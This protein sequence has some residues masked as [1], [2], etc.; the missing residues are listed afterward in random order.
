MRP[1]LRRRVR[2]SSNWKL[3][4][5]NH[6]PYAP[7]SRPALFQTQRGRWMAEI[8]LRKVAD[9]LDPPRL[10]RV[11]QLFRDSRQLGSGCHLERVLRG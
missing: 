8:R 2:G 1:L 5:R 7:P 9:F 3:H 6:F 4:D 10:R 11:V